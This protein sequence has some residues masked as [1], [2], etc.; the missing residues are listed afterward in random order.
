MRV[1]A[2]R[3]NRRVTLLRPS[4]DLTPLGS[5]TTAYREAGKRWASQLRLVP[6][7]LEADAQRQTLSRRDLL[8][9]RDSLTR[10]MTTEWRIVLDGVAMQV[11]GL[12]PDPA[13]GS[14]IVRCDRAEA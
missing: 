8:M 2:S 6:R 7:E 11:I 3:L 10:A 5:P 1:S 9:R 12:D 13:D 4:P 14:V